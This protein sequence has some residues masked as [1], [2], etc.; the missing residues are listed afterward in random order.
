MKASKKIKFA[1]L[2]LLIAAVIFSIHYFGL[3]SYLNPE[4][5]DDWIHG[6]GIFAPIVFIGIYALVTI[7]FLPG[8]PFSIL[9]GVLFGAIAGTIYVV[10]GATIGAFIAFLIARFLGEEFVEKL[11]KDK[12]HK[13]YEY[14]EKLEKNGALVVLFLRL[15]PLFPFNGLNFALGLTRVRWYHYLLGTFFGIIPG[16]FVFVYFGNSLGTLNVMNIVIAIVLLLVLIFAYPVFKHCKV[17]Y[18][19]RKA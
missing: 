11:L 16:T 17:R 7:V 15:V 6:F 12:F 13:L 18:Q 14:D 3:A 4:V 19:R 5:L 9:A 1:I 10:L 8:A 2:V